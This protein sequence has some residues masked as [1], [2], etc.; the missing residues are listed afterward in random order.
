[1]DVA[2]TALEASSSSPPFSSTE[3]WKYDVFLSF[4]GKD[5]RQTFTDHLYWTLKDNEVNAYIDENELRRGE[6]IPDELK[7]AIERSRISVIVFSKR[8]ADSTWCLEE[9][10]K[11]M[12]CRRARLG[13]MVLPVFYNVDPTHVRKQTGS[14]A[15]AFRRHEERFREDK[16]KVQR[17]RYAFTEAAN[18][19]GANLRNT[20]GYEGKFIRKIVDHITR[21]LNNTCL[22]VATNQIGIES[23]V[24]EVSN[25]LNVGRSDDVRI[26]GIWGMVGLGKTVVAKAIFN[27]FHQRFEGKSF[28]SKVREGDMVK[29]QNQLLCDILKPAK[30]KVRS[31]AEGTKEIKKRLSSI[32]ALVIIDDVDCHK[33]LDELAIKRDSFGPGS[34]IVITTT[35]AHFLRILEVDDTYFPPAMS[36]EEALQLLCCRAFTERHPSDEEYLELSRKVVEYCGGLPL[37]LEV[38][39]SYLCKRTKREWRSALRKLKRKPH[40]EIHEK[41][42]ISYDG[43]IDDEVQA[44]FLDICCFFIGMNKDHVTAILDGCDFDPL[45]GIGELHDRC[46]VSVDEGN[47]LMM[48]DLLRDMGREIVREKSPGIRG[49][50]SRLWDPE[51]V[52]DVLITNSGTERIEGVTLDLQGS[53]EPSFSAEALKNMQGLRLL[54]LKGVKFT[55]DCKHLS[56]R[57]RWLCWP[58]FPPE[59]IPEDFNQPNIVDIDLSHSCIQ[60]WKDSDMPLEKLKFLNLGYCDRLKQSPDFSKLPN[61]EKLILQGCNS[62]SEIHHSILQLKTLKYLCLADCNLTDEAIPEDLGDLT[63]LEELDLRGNVFNGLPTLSRLSRLQSLQL[64]NC[65]NLRAI[66]DLPTNLEIL[67]ADECIALEEMPNFSRM[68]CMRELHLNRSPKLTEIPGLDKSLNSM[69]RVHMEWCINLTADFKDAIIQGWS[70]CRNGC[71]FLPTNDFPSWLRSVDTKGEILGCAPKFSVLNEKL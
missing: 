48:H 20:D 7:H 68:L 56:K 9:L 64:T 42:K 52:T 34:R 10:E 21:K 49:K 15:Q 26:I 50:R 1:M 57:L 32:R 28:L 4:R 14:F 66:P 54:K 27:K 46:L 33:K 70:A 5:T 13:Q 22:D 11:I 2:S 67:Q 63:S 55:G 17:W 53:Q 43:L 71:L 31:I 29:L 51:D 18:L 45:L 25:Y 8:Y 36:N 61:L 38:L 69:T 60:V 16:D 19:A 6:N 23:R 35:N 62:L 3:H 65:A 39:G 59:A 30:K 37:A 40:G 24:R 41:L 12:E 44:I 58:G 47:N